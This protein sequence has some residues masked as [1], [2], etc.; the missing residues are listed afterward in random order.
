M[1]IEYLLSYLV[2]WKMYYNASINPGVDNDDEGA[3]Q[4]LQPSQ[5]RASWARRRQHNIQALPT[6]VQKDWASPSSRSA[7]R[8]ETLDKEW[9][10]FLRSS[11]KQA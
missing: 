4:P 3:S 9:Q 7:S 8:F 6:H 5:K 2:D 1:G 11:V 10:T